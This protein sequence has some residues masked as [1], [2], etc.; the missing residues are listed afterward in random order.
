[1]TKQ[2]IDQS[3]TRKAELTRA[4]ISPV[5]F[6]AHTHTHTRARPLIERNSQPTEMK[7]V[8][9]QTETT[10]YRVQIIIVTQIAN[11]TMRALEGTSKKENQRQR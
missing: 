4:M 3:K 6:A 11:T 10:P 9:A 8:P 2:F 7:S 5:W 1:M